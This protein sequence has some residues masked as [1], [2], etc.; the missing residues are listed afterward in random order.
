MSRF[1][2][3][4]FQFSLFFK[5]KVFPVSSSLANNFTVTSSTLAGPTQR[6]STG[7]SVFSTL[8]LFLIIK[9]A[10]PSTCPATISVLYPSITVSSLTVYLISFP[11]ASYLSRSVNSP[12]QL[13]CS[14]NFIVLSVGLSFF[15]NFT[16]ISL[17]LL[18]SWLLLS[19]HFFSTGIFTFSLLLF[20][21]VKLFFEFSFISLSYPLI[22]SSS[23]V[24]LI[25][26]FPSSLNLFKFLKVC[27][28][29]FCSFKVTSA[30]FVPSANKLT[31]T[32]EAFFPIQVLLTLASVFSLLL[33]IVFITATSSFTST[34]I[35]SSF[36]I[37][38][39]GAC[40]SS[41]L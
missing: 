9:P 37:Q 17:T 22:C 2:N 33:V 4:P 10:T 32:L 27:F 12:F 31:L 41:I 24:Y 15:N 18:P 29:L 1:V 20:I 26:V 6:F 36:F 14:F 35:I 16:I 40:I 21:I 19:S 38:P 23:T 11:C 5:V 39:A 13:F 3:L 8:C 25:S 34:S 28:Q 7:I 30:T